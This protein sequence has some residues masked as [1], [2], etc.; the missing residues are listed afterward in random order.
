MFLCVQHGVNALNLHIFTMTI[1]VQYNASNDCKLLFKLMKGK[2]LR[3]HSLHE[4]IAA[5]VVL[6]LFISSSSAV[7]VALRMI[8]VASNI[9]LPVHVCITNIQFM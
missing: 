6:K 1:I 9:Q 7:S 5:S 3:K 4:K 2:A 8:T